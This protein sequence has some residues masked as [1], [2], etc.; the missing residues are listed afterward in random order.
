M[1]TIRKALKKDAAAIRSLIWLVQ[2]NPFGLDWRHFLVAVN[3][4]EQV[5]ATG[6]IKPHRDGTRELAS[7]AT[8]PDYRSQGLASAIINR[9]LQETPRPL[10][11][12]CAEKMGLFY[13][14]FQFRVLALAEMPPDYARDIRRM[15]WMRRRMVPKM[16]HL[17]IMKLD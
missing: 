11:L 16:P 1:V 6:Q 12:R 8:R 10:Y 13:T 14:R 15:D 7:I 9:L 2:I 4:Q 5:V 17:L 3:E